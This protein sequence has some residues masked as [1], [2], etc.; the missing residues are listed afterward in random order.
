MSTLT[1]E[2][3]GALATVCPHCRHPFELPAIHHR[4]CRLSEH[5]AQAAYLLREVQACG[6]NHRDLTDA[7]KDFLERPAP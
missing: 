6:V 1:P 2:Q 5:L 7:I 3:C 4:M